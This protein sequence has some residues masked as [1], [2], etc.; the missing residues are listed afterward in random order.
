MNELFYKG[1]LKMNQ[2]KTRQSSRWSIAAISKMGMV[3][4]LY[5]AVTV[6]LSVISFGAI[7]IRL[8]EGFNFLAIYNKRYILSV[9][10]GVMIANLASP[11][12]IVDVV[13]GGS[14]TFLTL[15]C[16]SFVAGKLAHPIWKI[17]ATTLIF[18]CSMFTVAGELAFFYQL[19]FWSTWF[20]V[21]LGELIS[22]SLGGA[23]MHLV[24]K[25]ID[26]SI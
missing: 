13:I 25:K 20:V 18:S 8:S 10:L 11:L 22:M 3:T 23:L 17:V 24:N 5:V 15:L 4:A 7:Q 6:F 9:T 26:L 14:A 2:S 1:E 19:P 16:A 21:G 12:G